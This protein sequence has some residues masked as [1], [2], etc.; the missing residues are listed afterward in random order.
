MFVAL[1]FAFSHQLSS[2]LTNNLGFLFTFAKIDSRTSKNQVNPEALMTV[3]ANKQYICAAV[4][5]LLV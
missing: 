5:F 1:S 4:I 3:V 2:L